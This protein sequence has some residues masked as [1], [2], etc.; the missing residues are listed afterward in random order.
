M[1]IIVDLGTNDGCSIKKFQSILQQKNIKDYKIYS[2]EPHPYFYR[3]LQQYESDRVTI[4]PK[5]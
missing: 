4:I 5:L 1:H 3:H 2:F